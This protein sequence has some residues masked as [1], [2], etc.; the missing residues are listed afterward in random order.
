MLAQ[1]EQLLKTATSSITPLR[2]LKIKLVLIF[3][4]QIQILYKF[5]CIVKKIAKLT[6]PT[7]IMMHNPK[8][9]AECVMPQNM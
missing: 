6:E 8:L 9:I 4:I 5:R 2:Y 1:N 7:E 3:G